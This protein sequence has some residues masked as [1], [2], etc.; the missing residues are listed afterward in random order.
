MASLDQ[1]PTLGNLAVT[2]SVEA[3]ID[4]GPPALSQVLPAML[5]NKDLEVRMRA[6]YVLGGVLDNQFGFVPGKGF[7]DASAARRCRRMWRRLGDLD[8]EG[9]LKS[10][11][12]AVGLWRAWIDGGCKIPREDTPGSTSEEP[13]PR[14]QNDT[15]R[16]A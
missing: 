11:E 14:R 6:E 10:R 1:R 3:L 7:P 5:N 13:A 12:K 16:N 15:N 2:P 8:F 4:I 9:D